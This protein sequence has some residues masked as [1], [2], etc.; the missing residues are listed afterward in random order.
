M[1]ALIGGFRKF[2]ATAFPRHQERFRRL[3][4]IGQSPRTALVA[5]CDSRV[6]PQ[7]IFSAK[8]GELFVIRNVANLV[9]PYAP[10]GAYHGTSAALE[11]AVRQLG[12][13]EVIVM[14]HTLCGGV[15]ALVE[16][17]PEGSDFIG[18][19][20]SIA[21]DVRDR[22]LAGMATDPEQARAL[23]EREAIRQSLAN[24]MTFPWVRERVEAGEL[25]LR[26]CLF[27]VAAADLLV[28]DPES[29]EFRSVSGDEGEPARAVG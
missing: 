7:M 18:A 2:R 15:R 21:K 9:P 16:G 10:S 11:F 27:D 12:V 26:G 28:L 4:V 25:A 13:S 1:D 20:M 17:A 8:P 29:G 22:V 24:L 3:A 19:W 5:C 6:D 14:G 23:A